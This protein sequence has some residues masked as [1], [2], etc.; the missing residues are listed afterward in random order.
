[1][2]SSGRRAA[3]P[4][5]MMTVLLDMMSIGMIVPVLPK[6]VGTFMSSPSDIAVA[7]GAAQVCFALA[8]FFSA[9]ILGALSDR[10]GRRPVLLLGLFGMA[11]NFF[12]TALATE[13]WIL[14]AVR[15]M[16]GMVCANVAVANA[17]V[18]D[19]TDGHNRA[20]N[21]GLLGAMFGLG[22]MLGPFMGGVLGDKNVHLP[23]F[24]AGGLALLNCLYGYLVLPESLPAEK[25]RTVRLT[26]VSPFSAMARLRQL[27]EVKPL[28]WV[29]A[30]STLAQFM[31]H[32]SW[33][34]YT[35]FKFGWSPR[36]NGLS[37]FV[38]GLMAVIVQGGLLRHLQKFVSSSR[39]ASIGLVSATLAFVAWGAVPAGWMM[40]AVI[41]INV[42]GYAVNPTIQ[43]LISNAID[44]KKQ[45]ESMGALSSINSV[46][47]I[48]GPLLGA[49]VLAT[50][51]HYPQGDWRLGAPFYF[52][53][54]L[55]AMAAWIGIR[56]FS[57]RHSVAASTGVASTH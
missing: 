13:F 8:Q 52:C 16:G 30:L 18:A 57:R 36:D 3:M 24:V 21:Y 31:L 45:G 2:A 15:L 48:V 4:F 53:A 47:A 46:S 38:V 14:L 27:K 33:M 49:P 51:S 23:F 26:S 20:K 43:G 35:E 32:T 55:Q 37:L 54:V 11:V 28:L 34:L 29:I 41:V 6:L 40:Y 17:Y 22:F 42:F 25:R 19:I 56:H 9:P 7:Y 50:V 39:L 1:M 5:I 44:P 10:Y 12:V